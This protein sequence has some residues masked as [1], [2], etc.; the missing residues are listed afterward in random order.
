MTE[1]LH[2]LSVGSTFNGLQVP[3][4]WEITKGPQTRSYLGYSFLNLLPNH[5]IH[6]QIFLV[7]LAKTI[8]NLFTSLCAEWLP[9]P[10][11]SVSFVWIAVLDLSWPLVS[12]H[13]LFFP[14]P[15]LYVHST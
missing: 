12:L 7:L 5:P 13:P 15:T 2:V 3:C 14:P 4:K 6:S 10:K 11:L 8:P 1:M 9:Y